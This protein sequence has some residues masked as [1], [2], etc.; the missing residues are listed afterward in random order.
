MMVM[1]HQT[2]SVQMK[3]YVRNIAEEEEKVKNQDA[4]FGV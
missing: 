1:N 4:I 2:N 3:Q